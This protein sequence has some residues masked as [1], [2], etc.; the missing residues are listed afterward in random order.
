MKKDIA[1][2]ARTKE[3]LA[4]HKFHL[5]KSLGQNFLIDLNILNGIVDA[6]GFTEKD[7][8]IEIGPGI[9]ALTEQLAKKAKKVVAFEIDDRLIPVLEDTLS[10]Y[11]NIEI[12]HEDV[13]K[14]DLKSILASSFNDVE[15]IHVVANLPYYVTTPILMKLLEERLPLKSITVMIQAEVAERIAA[16]PSTKEYGSLSIAAQYY[17]EAKKKLHVPA[18][19]FVPPPRVD[20]AVL[21]LTIREQPLVSVKEEAWFFQVFHACFANRRKTIMNNLVHNLV[22]KEKKSFAEEA[23]H[24]ADIDPMRRGETLSIEEFAAL[25]DE[26][27]DL[28]N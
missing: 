19:V 1:T 2:P 21:K 9:G 10:P 28:R 6:S 14:A 22:G 16:V 27:Y 13:L 17:S 11:S 8:V 12:I 24:R 20:S 15:H 7:G 25:S 3:I 18:S 23:L 4:K 5:K 26:L